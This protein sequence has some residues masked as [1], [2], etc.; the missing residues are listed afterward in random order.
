MVNNI[1]HPKVKF[2]ESLKNSD[3]IQIFFQD[4]ALFKLQEDKQ[5]I[6]L[7]NEKYLLRFN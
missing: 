2:L 4:C 5:S 6:Y 1:F 7:G 3:F